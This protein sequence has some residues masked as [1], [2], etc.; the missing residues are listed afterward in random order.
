M[1]D[2]DALAGLDDV[3]WSQLQHAYGMADDV[4]R[5]LRAMQAGDRAEGDFRPSA[6]LVN[7]IVH[8][9]TRFEA[10]V[11]TVPFL[12]R[13]ALD[14]RLANRHRFVSLLASIAIGLDNNY[15]P[16]GYDA[17][18]ERAELA[19]MAGEADD[20]AQWIAEPAGDE[21]R[22][23]R[24][25]TYRQVL[26][27]VEAVERSYAAVREALPALNVLLTSED[28]ELRATTAYLLAWFP[29]SAAES[30]PLLQA[31][32]AREVSP[33]AAA[34]G[35]VA[36][37]LL[38]EPAAASF[39]EGYLDSPLA[40]LRWGAAFALNRLG[41][42]RP[43]VTD[44][45][46]EAVARPPEG[47]TTMPFLGG[48]YGGLAVMAL[49]GTPAGSTPRAVDAMLAGL[50]R[51]TGIEMHGD[52]H[53][54]AHA[55]FPQVFPGHPAEPP[56]AFS[57]LNSVQQHVVR[58]VVEGEI[59]WY[60]PVSDALERWDIPTRPIDLLAYVGTT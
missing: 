14:P 39:I 24:A 30:G 49:E 8:Q 13:M 41:N 51:C 6:L 21:E 38:G 50:A 22:R 19:E 18:A 46:I 35:L 11:Y 29:A 32:V 33:G 45:L 23:K 12:V 52:R 36:L 56:Q 34:T 16:N 57:Q 15:L 20:W 10:A 60:L 5:H 26:K 54:L 37:G 48:A 17:E 25:A 44:V 28:P 7:C 40:E 59:D 4:P 27:D 2:S 31:F 53:R 9:G 47:E 58:L 3:S 42:T 1:T 43:V 55:L